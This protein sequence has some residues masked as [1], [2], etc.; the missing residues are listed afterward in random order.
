MSQFCN[1]SILGK[2][3]ER[4]ETKDRSCISI[5]L[6]SEYFEFDDYPDEDPDAPAN[7][8]EREERRFERYCQKKYENSLK[9]GTL[10]TPAEW[11]K[12]N[13]PAKDPDVEKTMHN[14][15]RP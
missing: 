12:F 5:N 7:L 14:S 6:D 8:L 15:K 3:E 2:Y 4:L 13:H 11:D 1:P 10:R 9:K